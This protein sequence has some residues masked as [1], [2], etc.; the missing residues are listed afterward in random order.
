MQLS[1]EKEES[2]NL[3]ANEVNYA[4]KEQNRAQKRTDTG[5]GAVPLARGT[6][7]MNKKYSAQPKRCHT[8]GAEALTSEAYGK[9]S[10]L[11][12]SVVYHNCS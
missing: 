6:S 2:M 5:T 3:K 4:H 7:K 9:Y 8:E 11:L 12:Y 10:Q 1:L